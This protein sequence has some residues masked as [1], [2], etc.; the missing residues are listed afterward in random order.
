MNKAAVHDA[1]GEIKSGAQRYK[2]G[3]LKY[4]QMGYWQP[5]YA[6]K[7]TDILALFRITPQEGVPPEEAA[8]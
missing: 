6:P 3:V 4:R 1:A 8:A 5:D 2:A 7:P